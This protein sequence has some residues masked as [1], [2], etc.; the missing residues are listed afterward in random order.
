MKNFL[1]MTYCE[2]IVIM[3]KRDVIKLKLKL[4]SAESKK[5]I[6]PYRKVEGIKLFSLVKRKKEKKIILLNP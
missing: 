2:N 6:K 4:N 3:H 5:N 1:F